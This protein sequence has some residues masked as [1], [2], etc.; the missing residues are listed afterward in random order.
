MNLP[1]LIS[2][3]RLVAVPLI[4]WLI[5]R[6]EWLAA[7]WL[8]VAAGVSDAVDGFIAKK[9]GSSTVLG[10][11]LDPLADKALIV[12]IYVTLGYKGHLVVWLVIMVVFRDLLIIGGA[13]VF[14]AITRTLEMA[15]LMISKVNTVAQIV[16]AAVILGTDG[17]AVD[18][19][20]FRD[21]LIY[22]VAITTFASG[23]AYVVTWTRMASA[24]EEG[25]SP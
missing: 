2:L 16:L 13:L 9:F 4:V 12:A 17:F 15:P 23:A 25:K 10:S 14:Q 7:F 19:G 5:L 6:E 11:F 18:V 22:L 8:F 24:I 20:V 3:A 1:N 21:L